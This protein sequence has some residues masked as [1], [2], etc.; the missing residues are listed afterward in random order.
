MCSLEVNKRARQKP[1][2]GGGRTQW[3]SSFFIHFLLIKLFLI[4]FARVQQ[5]DT[6]TPLWIS[7]R[8]E[9]SVYASCDC[10]GEWF[11]IYT[12]PTIKRSNSSSFLALQMTNRFEGNVCRSPWL[13]HMVRALCANH[14]HFMQFCCNFSYFSDYSSFMQLILISV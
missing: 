1:R 2:R 8:P 5:C 7:H 9:F 4:T 6:E 14:F 3:K 10:V 13:C 11:Y 12:L